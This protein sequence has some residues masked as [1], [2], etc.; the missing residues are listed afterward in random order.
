MRRTLTLTLV[1]AGALLTLGARWAEK[2]I[3]NVANIAGEWRGTGAAASGQ[4]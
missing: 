2:P 3:A 1:I 4:F